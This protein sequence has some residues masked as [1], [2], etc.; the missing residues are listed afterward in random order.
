M[1]S[2]SV[3]AALYALSVSALAGCGI[4]TSQSRAV[5][6]LVDASGNYAKNMDEAVSSSR[7]VAAR[8]NPNDWMAFA[9]IGSCSFSDDAIV[10][11]EKLP[12]TPSRASLTKQHLFQAFETYAADVEPTAFTDIRGALRYAAFELESNA[13]RERYIVVF[14]DMVEDV[15]PDCDT[16]RLALDL[17]G[18]TVIAANVT[19]LPSDA[20]SPD[21]YFERLA[22][23]EDIVTATGGTW[24]HAPSA[25]QII[26]TVF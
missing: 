13:A 26:E 4:V 23:W 11:R 17:T 5:F 9:E 20:Q 6:V 15:S 22:K 2:L 21:R 3:L 24:V 19:K 12:S 8:L 16:S 1:N 25:E 7:L 14:S 10:V 18:I